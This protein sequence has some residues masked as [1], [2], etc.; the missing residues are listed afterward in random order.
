[1]KIFNNVF[2]TALF[3]GAIAGLL[4]AGI[5][6]FTVVPMILKAES[7]EST[8]NTQAAPASHNH[9]ANT[10]HGDHHGD[11]NVASTG[12]HGSDTWAPADGFERT[13]YTTL[14]SVAVGI[15]F[16]LLLTA[17]YAFRRTI[18]WRSGILWG[19]AGFAVFNLAPALG[20]PPKLPGD[21][22]AGLEA[23]Q[24]WW[25]CTALV[26]AVG[27]WLI[28][29]QSAFYQKLLGAALLAIPHIFG[30]PQPEVYGGLAPEEL[31]NAFMY[32]S[33]LSNAVFWLALGGLSAYF[34]SR[35]KSQDNKSDW[36]RSRTQY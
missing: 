21:S 3:A 5:Q 7:Y 4:L 12:H 13:F 28:V 18:T 9:H 25:L 20:L 30:A 36:V 26:T 6:H 2:L 33:L 29:F 31:R 34:F 16:G 10:G 23:R 35:K 22:A 14:N 17:C 32:T 1:M 27:L 15:G 8:G 11:H 24:I 19:L